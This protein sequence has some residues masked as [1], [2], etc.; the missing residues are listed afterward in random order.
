MVRITIVVITL[1]GF[2]TAAFADIVP[3]NHQKMGAMVV[4]RNAENATD[5]KWIT[6]KGF[7]CSNSMR[8]A[9]DTYGVELRKQILELDSREFHSWVVACADGTSYILSVH[10]NLEPVRSEPSVRRLD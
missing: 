3:P 7:T 4:R 1:L 5:G 2:A 10:R 8:V 9:P 6:A